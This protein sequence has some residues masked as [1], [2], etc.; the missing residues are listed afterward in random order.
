[1]KLFVTHWVCHLNM[2][3]WP[4]H[5]YEMWMLQTE[6]TLLQFYVCAKLFVQDG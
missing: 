3:Q 1:M 5:S 4:N 6:A 2:A